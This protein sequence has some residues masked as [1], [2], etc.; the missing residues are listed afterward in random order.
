MDKKK[1]E[2]SYTRSLSIIL[3][4]AA[5]LVVVGGYI[6][7]YTSRSARKAEYVGDITANGN[8]SSEDMQ[9]FSPSDLEGSSQDKTGGIGRKHFNIGI[10]FSLRGDYD[11]AIEEYKKALEYDPDVAEIHSNMAFAYMDTKE[12][13]KSIVEQRKAIEL[14]PYLVNAY[15]GLA[16]VLEK[17]GDTTGA[18]KNWEKYLEM[19]PPNTVWWNK[20]KEKLDKIKMD[21]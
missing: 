19:A 3:V 18:L 15:Y 10:R 1:K 14:N 11:R 5:V 17:K 8:L 12:F 21:E 16:L 13:E 4:V 20:A 6:F 2:D 9:H 7:Y